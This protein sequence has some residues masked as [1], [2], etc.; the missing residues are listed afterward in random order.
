[1]PTC[2]TTKAN[3]IRLMKATGDVNCDRNM[4]G[5]YR[6]DNSWYVIEDMSVCDKLRNY[7]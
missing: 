6:G 2:A 7:P 4:E 1:M 5:T 3:L